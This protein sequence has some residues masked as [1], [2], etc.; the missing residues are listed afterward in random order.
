MISTLL[1]DSTITV[2]ADLVSSVRSPPAFVGF[3]SFGIESL[4]IRIQDPRT[5]SSRFCSLTTN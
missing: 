5:P 1:P 2:L 3:I 4:R